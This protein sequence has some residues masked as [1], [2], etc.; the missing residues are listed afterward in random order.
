MTRSGFK[1]AQKCRNL[2]KKEN[3]NKVYRE[4]KQ[5]GY[6]FAKETLNINYILRT[7]Y[8]IS[9]NEKNKNYLMYDIVFDKSIEPIFFEE[10]T[11]E[12]NSI[13]NELMKFPQPTVSR[14]HTHTQHSK[15]NTK[16]RNHARKQKCD[17]IEYK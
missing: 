12:E 4:D 9:L 2:Q 14:D 11:P 15:I 13:I 5:K 17:N 6:F 10:H 8:G 1:T 3:N 7:K 16:T